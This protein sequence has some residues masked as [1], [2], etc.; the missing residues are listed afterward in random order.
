MLKV[1][2]R[3]TEEE[4]MGIRQSKETVDSGSKADLGKLREQNEKLSAENFEYAVENN[5]IKKKLFQTQ[6]REKLIKRELSELKTEHQ[7]LLNNQKSLN[8]SKKSEESAK[9][10]EVLEKT[11]KEEKGKVKNLTEWKSQLSEKNKELK[12]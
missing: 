6:D 11:M 10:I 2:L 4:I 5:D 3:R 9:E 12:Q 1:E 8:Q 7:W